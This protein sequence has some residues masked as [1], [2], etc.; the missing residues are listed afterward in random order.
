MS[1]YV[2]GKA[3]IHSEASNRKLVEIKKILEVDL[4]EAMVCY[5]FFLTTASKLC[6]LLVQ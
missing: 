6:A 3:V 5:N 4:D 1:L 2:T